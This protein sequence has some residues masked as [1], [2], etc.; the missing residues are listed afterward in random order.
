MLV[1]EKDAGPPTQRR[2]SGAAQGWHLHHLL[3]AG[4]RL[5]ESI[6]PGIIDDM[7]AAGAFKVDMGEQYRI[8]LAGSWKK[9]GPSGV[10]IVCAG[11]PLLE[12]CVR[13]R[14]D[15]EPAID[16]RYESEVRDLVFDPDTRRVIAVI[17]ERDGEPHGHS[18]RI[19]GRR[20]GQEHARARA[21]SS[22]PASARRS[23]KKIASIASIRPCSTACRRSAHGATR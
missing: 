15:C 21:C 7:V 20:S 3:I 2:P 18:R 10:E 12:W 6:F 22:A 11:R 5:L 4:Q 13:R 9:V 16:Y 1:L 14:L 8:M 17:V 19:R 23:S